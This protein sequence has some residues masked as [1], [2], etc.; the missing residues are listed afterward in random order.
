MSSRSPPQGIIATAISAAA[1]ISVIAAVVGGANI[2][3][4]TNSFTGSHTT[5]SHL[6]VV[7]GQINYTTYNH[8]STIPSTGGNLTATNQTIT[9]T[10][11]HNFTSTVT[12]K[13]GTNF[14]V[15][16]SS[17]KTKKLQF[18]VASISTAHTVTKTIPNTNGT[19]VDTAFL[20]STSITNS[21]QAPSFNST[22]TLTASQI[23]KNTCTVMTYTGNGTVK[24]LCNIGGVIKTLAKAS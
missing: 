5:I 1:L 16:D 4:G 22:S 19:V 11:A 24:E 3:T 18:N 12:V 15:V 17:D 10:G 23:P 9:W 8:I 2:F 6:E 21:I 7:N 13:S 14:N 20:N